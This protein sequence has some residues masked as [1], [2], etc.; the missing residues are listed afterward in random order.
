MSYYLIIRGPLGAG[1]TTVAHALGEALGAEVISI[2]G[3]LE[4]QEWD[5]GS[6]ELFLR[7]NELAAG[8]ARAHLARG[9]PVVL[10]GNFYWASALD[11]LARRLPFPHETFTLRVPLATCIARDRLRPLSYGEEAT[12]EVFEKVARVDRGIPIDGEQDLGRIVRAIRA[13]LPP[14]G[15]TPQGGPERRRSV[16]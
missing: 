7:T 5:G 9:T 3:L 6:E 2:D 13:H 1:K 11:D 15:T 12:Q 10:D 4:L 8:T 14:A 16:P